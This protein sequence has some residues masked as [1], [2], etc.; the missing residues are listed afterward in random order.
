MRPFIATGQGS[1]ACGLF[2]VVLGVPPVLPGPIQTR[3]FSASPK[4]CKVTLAEMHEVAGTGWFNAII[5][6]GAVLGLG[7]V[8]GDG[9]CGIRGNGVVDLM[10]AAGASAEIIGGCVT[11]GCPRGTRGDK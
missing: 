9:A 2:D 3:S 11:V 4:D 8:A 6:F 10:G 1:R 5:L 7:K